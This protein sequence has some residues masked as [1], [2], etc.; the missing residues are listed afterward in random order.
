MGVTPLV[1]LSGNT[2]DLIL[3]KSGISA[4]STEPREDNIVQGPK[5]G[6][7]HSRTYSNVSILS[8]PIRECSQTEFCSSGQHLLKAV[9]PSSQEESSEIFYGFISQEREHTK[10]SG[11]RPLACILSPGET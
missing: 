9:G 1:S 8:S 3:F 11:H 6:L 10:W 5:N 7:Y 2:K 4:L